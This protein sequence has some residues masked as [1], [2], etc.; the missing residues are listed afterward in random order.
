MC[1]SWRRRLQVATAFLMGALYAC[2]PLLPDL[3]ALDAWARNS[4]AR[5]DVRKPLGLALQDSA[6]RDERLPMAIPPSVTASPA[7]GSMFMKLLPYMEQGDLYGQYSPTVNS[8]QNAPA[9]TVI[10]TYLSPSDSFGPFQQNPLG[11]N[12]A[13]WMGEFSPWGPFPAGGVRT[14]EVAMADGTT[15]TIVVGETGFQVQDYFRCGDGS[16][17]FSADYLSPG[18][19]PALS[20]RNGG[21][22][23]SDDY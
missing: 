9:N 6:Q 1:A 2:V 13:G 23:I 14:I 10:K 5:A 18:R 7:Y 3:V 19:Y 12:Y 15:N 21:E 8:W 11:S 16:H 4:A 22:A 17:H 20:T